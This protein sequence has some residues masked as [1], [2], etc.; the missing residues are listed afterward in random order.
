MTAQKTWILAGLMAVLAIAIAACGPAATPT[1]VPIA[2]PTHTPIPTATPTAVPTHTPIPTATPTAAPTATATAATYADPFAYCGIV[3][4]LDKPDARYTGQPVPEAVAVALRKASG[5]A[6]DAPLELFTQN[7]YWRC[8]GGKVYGCF[9]GANIPCWDKAN[10][11]RT[12]TA[13]ETDF[14]KAQPNVD[15]IPAY[16]TG[17]ETVYEWRCT[18]GKP[19]IVRQVLQVDGRGFAKDFWYELSPN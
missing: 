14:C 11:D 3:G 7:S 6:P 5:A 1:S 15:G 4:D 13:A 18:Q 19:E 16:V 9:V 17:H 8:M 2:T 12:P 10:T